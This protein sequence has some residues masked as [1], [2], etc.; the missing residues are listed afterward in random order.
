M[1]QVD[2]AKNSDALPVERRSQKLVKRDIQLRLGALF[3]GVST[4]CLLLQW[5]LL[6]SLLA[7]AARK[8]PV[9]GEY[10]LDLVPALLNQTLLLSAVIAL[11]LTLVAGIYATFRISG[12]IYRF[13][14]YLREV[15]RGTQLG[16]CK[17]R[18]GDALA[19]LC[20]LINEATEPLRKRQVGGGEGDERER[21]AA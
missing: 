14:C 9:G 20:D 17:I 6:S 15:I 13:E 21:R 1:S 11:P 8:M 10:L 19:E 16:P 4:L 7:N 5:L 3:A 12:P 2:P 18:E